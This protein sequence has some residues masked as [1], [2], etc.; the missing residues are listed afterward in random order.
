MSS[1]YTVSPWLTYFTPRPHARVRLF[2]IPH[3]GGGAQN[4]KDWAEALPDFIEVVA[5]SFPGRG[6]RYAEPAI[7]SMRELVDEI[8]TA[9]KPLLDKPYAFFGHSVGA[10]VAYEVVCRIEQVK[11]KEGLTLKLPMRLMTSAH[12]VPA[13]SHADTPMYQLS[14][15]DLLAKI[16]ELG[17]VPDEALQNKDLVD[18]ILPPL[19]ADFEISETYQWQKAKP[20]TVPI[21]ATMG[22][23]D[24]LLTEQDMQGW[25]AYTSCNFTFKC[26]EGDHFYTVS[27]LPEL[28][29]DISSELEQDLKNQPL[30]MMYGHSSNYPQKC[31]HELFREQAKRHPER[32][33]ICDPTQ[34]LS[35]KQLDEQTDILAR[36]LQQRGVVVDSLVSIFMESSV[37]YVVAYLAILKAG[38]AY[39][40]LETAYPTDLLARVLTKTQPITILTTSDYLPQLP[41]Q[42]LD[43]ELAVSL[44]G[45]WMSP[46]LNKIKA[47]EL[48]ELDKGRKLPTLDS[49]AYCVMSSGT[50]GEPK[51]IL[52]PH[53]GAVNSYYWR[54]RNHP[55]QNGEREAANVFFV[56]EVIRPL[57]QGYP[58]YIIPDSMIYDPWQLVDY[59]EVNDITRVL[60]TPS[61]L[62]Q[63]LNTPDLDL[64]QRLAKLQIVWLNGEVVPTALCKRFFEILP[65]CKLINDYSISETHDVCTHDL[66]TLDDMY[67]PKFAPLGLPMSNVRIYLLDDNL[68]PV[69]QGIPAEVYVAGDS[70]ARCYLGDPDKTAERFLPDPFANKQNDEANQP[71]M[72]RTGDMGRIL[73][74]GELEI[75]GRVEFMIKLRG[76]TVVL[77]A[78]EASINAHKGVHSSAVITK[79]NE[80]TDQ[81]EALVAYIVSNGTMADDELI[82]SLKEHLKGH[83]PQ[84]AVPSYFMPIKALP[85]HAVTGKLDRKQLPEPTSIQTVT[86]SDNS[87]DTLMMVANPIEKVILQ[88]WQKHLGVAA[89]SLA[90]NFFDLGG[91][92]LL[93]IQVC[94]SISKELGMSVSVLDIFTNPTIASLASELATKINHDDND[95]Q[96]ED[97]VE[98]SLHHQSGDTSTE[99]AIVG[100]AARFPGADNIDEFWDNL[101]DGVCSIRELTD[102]ELDKNGVP[103]SVYSDENYRKVGAVLDNV[104]YFDSRFW[105]LSKKEA[106]IMD[107]QHRLFLETCWHALEHAGYVPNK[108]GQRTGVFGGCYSP[109]YL[110]HNLAGGGFM[111]ATDPIGYH[112]TETGNDKDYLTTRVSYLLNLQG[113]SIAVQSSCSTALSVVASACESLQTRHCDVALAGASSITFPQAGYQYVEGHINSKDGKIRTFDAAANGTILGDGVGVV[114]LKRLDDAINAGD[115]I[116]AVIKGYA[117]N[118]DGNNK[119]GYSAPS[120]KGQKAVIT[121]AL[122]SAQVTADSISYVEAHGTGT[123]IGDPIEVKALTEVF[124]RYSQA[125]NFCA[126]GSVKP[127]IGHS[128][129]AAGMAS[130]M[131]VALSLYHK[132]IPPTLNFETPNPLIDIENSPFYINNT[133]KAWQTPANMPRRAGVTCLGIGGTNNHF[134]L[135]EAPDLLAGTND[136]LANNESVTRQHH[137][138][139]VSGKT[140]AARQRNLQNLADYLQKYPELN[141]Q[142]VEFTLQQGRYH[143]EYRSAVS[144]VN[145]EDAIAN[146][147]L[148]AKQS[149]NTDANFS[150]NKLSDK[151]AVSDIKTVFLFPGQGS[152]HQKMGYDL[153]DN[154]P[155]FKCHFDECCQILQP[156]LNLDIRTLL[157]AELGSE[158]A[159]ETFKYA[160]YTQPMIVAHQIAMARTLMDWGIK[161]DAVAGHSIGEYTAAYVAGIF[162]LKDILTLIVARG[163]AMEKAGEGRMLSVGLSEAKAHNWLNNHPDIAC[164]VS[165][166]VINT[167]ESV[168]LSGTTVSIEQA[169]TALQNEGIVCQ[170]VNVRQ[171]FHSAMM[172]EP[173]KALIEAV[174]PLTRN[175]PTMPIMSNVTGTWMTQ[176]QVHDDGYWAAHMRGTVN[177]A[178]NIANLLK[179]S[180]STLIEAGASTILSKLLQVFTAN[181]PV[182]E[183][184]LVTACARHPKDNS[185]LDTGALDK[186]ISQ[187]WMAGRNIDWASYRGDNSDGYKQSQH[188]ARRIG[189]P[190]YAFEPE[191]C[192]VN[193]GAL[194]AKNTSDMPADDNEMITNIS[195]RGFI[196]SWSRSAFAIANK[197]LSTQRWLIVSSN[198]SKTVDELCAY[199]V[200]QL[201]QAN[202]KVVVLNPTNLQLNSAAAYAN[203]FNQLSDNG[204]FPNRVLYLDS[205][206]AADNAN[207]KQNDSNDIQIQ[208]DATYYPALY[209]AQGLATQNCLDPVDVWLLTD[210]TFQV[211]DEYINPIKSTL[212]GV[213]IV[214]PQEYPQISCR[215]IDIC[216]QVANKPAVMKRILTEISTAN[217]DSEPF[218]ALRGSKRWVKRYEN[219]LI[220]AT[221][222]NSEEDTDRHSSIKKAGT[223]LIT[224]GLG[225]IAG[226]L[227]THLASYNANL[228]LTTTRE[229]PKKSTWDAIA[230]LNEQDT[231]F[232]PQMR[233]TIKHLQQL[234]QAGAT[235][236]VVTTSL[237][238][239]EAVQTLVDETVNEFGELD[240]VFHL[241]G[242]ADLRYLPEIDVDISQKE[243]EPKV[244][245]LLNISQALKQCIKTHKVKPDFVMLFSSLASILGGYSMTAYTA[246]NR[247]MDSYAAANP[248]RHGI[249]WFCVNWDD[250]DFDYSKE[251]TT[252]YEQTVAKFAM[253][254]TDGIETIER[255]LAM[256]EPQQWLISTRPLSPR[257]TKWLQ[258]NNQTKQADNRQQLSNDKSE[259]DENDLLS[260]ILAVYC[261]VLS[262]PDYQATDNFFA[263]GGDSLLASQILLQLQRNLS[264]YRESLTLASIFD[265]ATPQDLVTF[266]EGT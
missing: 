221:T 112:M 219:A 228:V 220:P 88:T 178:S 173:S 163:R 14:D 207:V 153:Y 2:C 236:K 119:T 77:G 123:L 59:L 249:R 233:Q 258:Q 197:D 223:Y 198:Q 254:I 170:A 231:D 200:N 136:E 151:Q 46:I 26:Y 32:I 154:E 129:I 37:E 31:L 191:S 6:S 103:K 125:Q 52:C 91:H 80:Q 250:W 81:P 165:V 92:S 182:E 71:I 237:H 78:V 111:D 192:W 160:Y 241:A 169:Q 60:F 174:R 156:L 257:V 16:G 145:I 39:M 214:L 130:L 210:D 8:V 54:Y 187:L 94:R 259:T 87:N 95:K 195:N 204:Q 172:D 196:P 139:V 120:V 76:Y 133:L 1:N 264:E 85:L 17:L 243:F 263:A 66:T 75:T 3:G 114:V 222:L 101:R 177:F 100:M 121:G 143:F 189:L 251:Q 79:D 126:L 225:R 11:Q 193:K 108:N 110:L 21:T 113:P 55:Y 147:R 131:K 253:P 190:G 176:Q 162:S 117:N 127:N 203:Y 61:L 132:Q 224:G 106:E 22:D 161:P 261:D 229:F 96:D 211:S 72:F 181:M 38:G 175:T 209:F 73:P 56:W 255:L 146:L 116:Y 93:A 29:A 69:P 34:S 265:N 122:Q 15:A 205:L 239:L 166:G 82:A 194:V 65:N 226:S 102:D 48:P 217:V 266:L 186:A 36:Y 18:F 62:E 68:Q 242:L 240:G 5:L 89:T 27:K 152:Q 43:N 206:T 64:T 184:P 49:L 41:K 140:L 47:G 51:G 138:L 158:K 144:C 141:L 107:P 252:A 84:Y 148:V 150:I 179:Q 171:A 63:I 53:R 70:L 218:I 19:R 86:A 23:K 12:K 20:L 238:A 10:L 90:D 30:S 4:F 99:L 245:G 235:V 244:A 74:N 159:K 83:L 260:R 42:W 212:L 246:A 227:C 128:N 168:V 118:N 13:D 137:L 67:S 115:T 149:L 248:W 201:Q 9:I 24:T 230:A 97:S 44:D 247:F 50:T 40:P 45:D 57:L 199:L 135:E 202:A 180:P 213:A 234:E 109:L 216:R 155:V 98:V 142:D 104:D 25:K 208:L 183:R 7:H 188:F 185:T 215:T 134:V 58:A 256:S 262:M 105:Q 35:F 164:D 232:D 28:L 167:P 157:F 124:R 33:A